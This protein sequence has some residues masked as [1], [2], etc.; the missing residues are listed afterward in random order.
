M[1]NIYMKKKILNISKHQGDTN[2]N[3]NK[4]S[5]THQNGFYKNMEG[6]RYWQD[7]EEG[8]QLKHFWWEISVDTMEPSSSKN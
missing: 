8:E 5:H 3:H 6:G 7:M 1:A 2:E 4:P